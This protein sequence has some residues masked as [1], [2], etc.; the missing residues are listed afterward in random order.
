MISCNSCRNQNKLQKGKE[1]TDVFALWIF[2]G[3]PPNWQTN[4]KMFKLLWETFF[5]VHNFIDTSELY[6]HIYM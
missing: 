5:V 2:T 1:F 3:T 6:N 4:H